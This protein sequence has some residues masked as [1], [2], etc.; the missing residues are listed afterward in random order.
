MS[1]DEDFEPKV[2][3]QVRTELARFS[4]KC[5]Y[6]EVRKKIIY[7]NHQEALEA[8]LTIQREEMERH[9]WLESEKARCDL[10]ENLMADWI[11]KYSSD[12]ARYWR[13]THVYIPSIAATPP[14]QGPAGNT[15]R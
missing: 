3:A 15:G 6:D 10:G 8:Y 12:F 11:R 4:D 13:R 2:A 7:H 14:P 9:R 1:I 5:H